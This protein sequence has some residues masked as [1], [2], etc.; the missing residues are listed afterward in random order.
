MVQN[1]VE[2][3]SELM[4][5]SLDSSQYAPLLQTMSVPAETPKRDHGDVDGNGVLL[6]CLPFFAVYAI[7]GVIYFAKSMYNR[8]QEKSL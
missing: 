8:K 4:P 1:L 6:G 5:N 7:C 3:A 2:R